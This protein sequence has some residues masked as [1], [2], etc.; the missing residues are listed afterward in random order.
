MIYTLDANFVGFRESFTEV[1]FDWAKEESRGLARQSLPSTLSEED[2]MSFNTI[3][4]YW[5]L[6]GEAPL[7]HAAVRGGMSTHYS[8]S[9]VIMDRGMCNCHVLNLGC[10]AGKNLPHMAQQI[11]KFYERIT[12]DWRWQAWFCRPRHAQ[13]RCILVIWP[14]QS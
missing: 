11:P 4:Y 2:I 9:Q 7:L 1:V 13:G 12:Y 8:Y 14:E 6:Q 3:D 5:Q 10:C